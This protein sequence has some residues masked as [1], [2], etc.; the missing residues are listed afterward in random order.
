MA[1]SSRLACGNSRRNTGRIT[2]ARPRSAPAFSI[3][4]A[5]ALHRHSAPEMCIRDS[6]GHLRPAI[7]GESIKRIY[8]YFGDKVIGDI[9]L[10]DWGL[11]MG[12]SLIHI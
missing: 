10:G 3:S 11:Q 7:I 2:R 4:F 6:V 1:V 5:S 9:H 8:R 12:L